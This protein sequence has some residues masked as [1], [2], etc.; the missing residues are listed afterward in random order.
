MK[1]G[2]TL[3]LH[4]GG[5]WK[6]QFTFPCDSCSISS[7]GTAKTMATL[8]GGKYGI[9]TNNHNDVKMS[10]IYITKTKDAGV[11]ALCT[12][13][14]GTMRGT[15]DSMV[16]DN[17]GWSGI[18]VVNCNSATAPCLTGWTVTNNYSGLINLKPGLNYN[19][20]GIQLGGVCGALVQNNNVRTT[21]AMGIQS[22]NF[23]AAAGS[24]NHIYKNQLVNNEG[25]ITAVS[26]SDD[27]AYNSIH[28]SRGFGIQVGVNGTAH[29]DTILNLT[30]ST[31]GTLYNGIDGNGATNAVYARESVINVAGC[32]IT[33]EGGA[34]G[35]TI[36]GGAYDASHGG[37]C[38][39]YTTSSA[40]PVKFINPIFWVTSTSVA[41]PYGYLMSGPGDAAHKYSANQ[42]AAMAK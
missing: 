23:Y 2:D 42:W 30:A 8:T 22:R 39:L 27:V 25:N 32:A 31:D 28:D 7:Y 29:D 1:S 3:L 14:G 12:V 5:T 17:T 41:K 24:N 11:A 18:E 20:S 34:T 21:N 15:I 26:P 13:P 16:V 35:T 10:K 40:G 36:N 19:L 6:E 9:F 33:V 38:A 37:Q 4:A